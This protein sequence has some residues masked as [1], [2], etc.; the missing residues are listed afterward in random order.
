MPIDFE[1]YF[2]KVEELSHRMTKKFAYPLHDLLSHALENHLKSNPLSEI[3]KDPYIKLLSEK[4]QNINQGSSL[5]LSKW[6][7]GEIKRIFAN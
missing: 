5:G 4:N 2:D 1:L 6:D 3:T 7:L